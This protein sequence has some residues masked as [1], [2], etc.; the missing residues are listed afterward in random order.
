MRSSPAHA[1]CRGS[2]TVE[3][4]LVMPVL[5]L[6]CLALVQVGVFARDQLLVVQASRAGARQAAVDP[7]D[8]SVRAAAAMAAPGLE[9]GRLEIVVERAGGRGEPVRVTVGYVDP[10]RVPLAGLLFPSEA[11][12][13]AEAVM[14]QEFG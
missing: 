8:A 7:D 5:L 3:F 12:L 14:R 1:G 11:H 2:A 4:A 10:V 6:V 13:A 9:A